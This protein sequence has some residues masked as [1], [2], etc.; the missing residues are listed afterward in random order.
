MMAQLLTEGTRK[1]RKP[2]QCFHCYRMIEA[3]TEYGFQTC[4]Y[5]S[6]YTLRWH[7]D[8]EEMA[9]RYRDPSWYAEEGWGPLRDELQ[10]SGEY[11]RELDWWRGDFP[12][13]VC[14]MELT[15]QLRER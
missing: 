6:V 4:K 14:R 11:L 7:L 8:C 13:V 2:H 9:S 5:D 3:G 15:D 1:A 10:G 12:H